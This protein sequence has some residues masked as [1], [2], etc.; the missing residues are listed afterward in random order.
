MFSSSIFYTFTRSQAVIAPH[1]RLA[2]S[3]AVSR[4]LS[5]SLGDD[6]L[7]VTK[8]DDVASQF[9]LLTDSL[10]RRVSFDMRG[11]RLHFFE[12]SVISRLL[13]S[14]LTPDFSH[15]HRSPPIRERFPLIR[16]DA[17]ARRHTDELLITPISLKLAVPTGLQH[18][19]SR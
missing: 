3:H 4:V 10:I 14:F 15:Y 17:P 1:A 8:F 7:P 6:H 2:S 12:T 5:L 16:F 19:I 9:P 11:P 13:F 18:A